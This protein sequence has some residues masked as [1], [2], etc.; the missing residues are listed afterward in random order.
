MIGKRD[1]LAVAVVCLIVVALSPLWLPLLPTGGFWLARGLAMVGAI[2]ALA[3][4]GK[5]RRSVL[6]SPAF[7][8]PLLALV[9]Y[10][11]LPA[12]YVEVT[13]GGP[14]PLPP[15]VTPEALRVNGDGPVYPLPA[16]VGAANS[17][18]EIRNISVSATA[19]GAE[20]WILAFVGFGLLAAA[21][22]DL[23]IPTRN[24]EADEVEPSVAWPPLLMVCGSGLLFQSGK[25]LLPQLPAAASSLI[26]LLPPVVMFGMALLVGLCVRR[27]ARWHCAWAALGLAVGAALLLPYHIK[28][29]AFLLTTILLMGA[30]LLRGWARLAVIVVMIAAPAL[31]ANAISMA[32]S[33]VA[34]SSPNIIGKIIYRQSETMYCLEFARRDREA[35]EDEGQ[36]GPLY[37][38]AGLV[39]RVVWPDKPSLSQGEN[40]AKAFC[41]FD[42][43]NHSASITLLGEP[44]VRGGKWGMLA[45]GLVLTALSAL[46]VAAWKRGT[47]V[48]AAMALGLTPWLID[49]D[50]HFAMYVANVVKAL[51]AML[52]V[53]VVLAW[54]ARRGLCRGRQGMRSIPPAD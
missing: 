20:A 30:A 48:M 38:A 7:T 53:A 28:A 21:V 32:R 42:V 51:L 41:G 31:A 29:S 9:F 40:Y 54:S 44:A 52:A 12:A 15:Q 33:H 18:E 36:A 8:L 2:A 27:R 3:V 46:V 10:S 47:P 35:G 14:T 1:P 23:L 5:G 16:I 17:A 37:F 24:A 25:R 4:A 45:A 50:Q 43:P 26:D 13:Y 11:L 19:S 22:F 6:A 34:A 49:F 39:P